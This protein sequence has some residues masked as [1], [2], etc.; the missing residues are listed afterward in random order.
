MACA[1]AVAEPP[2][3]WVSVLAGIILSAAA[4]RSVGAAA[5][6]TGHIRSVLRR[7]EARASRGTGEGPPYGGGGLPPPPPHFR[8]WAGGAGGKALS[9]SSRRAPQ[10]RGAS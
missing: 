6:G 10:D 3:G 7:D 5:A 9:S 2:G 4:I 1:A 8:P